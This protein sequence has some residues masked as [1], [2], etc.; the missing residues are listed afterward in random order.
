MATWEAQV[1]TVPTGGF[2]KVQVEAGSAGTAMEVINHIYN[3]IQILNLRQIRSPI[4]SN[5]YGSGGLWLMGA[6]AVGGLFLYLTPY[7]L[8]IAYGAAA[9]YISQK[10]VGQTLAEY[11]EI[12][13]ED[14]KRDKK[15]GIVVGSAVLF[16]L[17]GF[18][19]GTIWHQDL[20]KTYI[21]NHS[22]SEIHKVHFLSDGEC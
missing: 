11:S 13:D 16:G 9:T 5:E 2:M 4:Q 10:A 19:H 17:I 22:T 12:K 18:I 3:P 20:N 6:V 8:S 7:M 1:R 14:E 15:A 21:N